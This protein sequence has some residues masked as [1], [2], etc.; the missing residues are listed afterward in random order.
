MLLGSYPHFIPI[1]SRFHLMES[2][3]IV[4]SNSISLHGGYE[5][6]HHP[7]LIQIGV[8]TE[9]ESD[10]RLRTNSRL[11]FGFGS[12]YCTNR[13][14]IR[15]GSTYSTNRFTIRYGSTYSFVYGDTLLVGIDHDASPS[16]QVPCT[17][18]PRA[19]TPRALKLPHTLTRVRWSCVCVCVCVLSMSISVIMC[20]QSSHFGSLW[21]PV[22]PRLTVAHRSRSILTYRS[23]SLSAQ[24]QIPHS[25]DL[26]DWVAKSVTRQDG[27]RLRFL[28]CAAY[29]QSNLRAV[30]SW[31]ICALPRSV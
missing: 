6:S 31:Y 27:D 12:T 24:L 11:T 15:F 26:D 3:S 10:I 30:F 5:W 28:A 9:I 7:N 19:L 17:N 13:V 16:N 23:Q 21:I 20:I 8:I 1:S 22:D 4:A 25:S 14:A 2:H 29:S 18:V